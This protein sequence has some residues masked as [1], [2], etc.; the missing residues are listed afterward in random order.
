MARYPTG[1]IADLKMQADIVRVI[2]EVVPLKKAGTS[3][4]GLCPFHNEKTPSFHVH[5]DKGFFHCFGCSTGGDVLKFVELYEKLSFPEAVKSLAQRFG[6][7]LPETD[8]AEH[9]HAA[10]TE[11]EALLKVHELAAAYFRDQLAAP[12][13]GGARAYL[14]QRG[15][16]PETIDALCLARRGNRWNCSGR[17]AL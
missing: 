1:F 2:Q 15:I 5:P 6:L 8:D 4:K 7:Q 9:D 10:E 14:E 13:G 16:Q 12:T 17:V 3:Y 11:R